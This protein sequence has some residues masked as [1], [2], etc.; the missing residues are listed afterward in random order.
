M[1]NLFYPIVVAVIILSATMPGFALTKPPLGGEIKVE[2]VADNEKEFHKIAHQDLVSGPTR[3]I[4]RYLEAKRGEQYAIVVRNNTPE[5]IGLVIAVDGRNIISGKRSELASRERMYV[6]NGYE[7]GRYEGWRTTNEEVHRFY[8]TK[9]ADSYSIR[10][11]GDKSAMGLIAVAVYREKE[12]PQPLIEE[13]SEL[14][15]PSAPSASGTPRSANKKLADE[16][17][18][19]FGDAHY[20]PVITVEFE[21]EGIPFQKTLVKYEWRETLCRKGLL[22]CGR[23]TGNRFWDDGGYAP[24]PP[25]YR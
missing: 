17:G 13:K 2:I 23:E 9:P 22:L 4:K 1:R 15:A 7:S 5:R 25:A 21:P 16:A 19:G 6:L 10:A 8:F 14:T 18:T 20:S 24:Y 3:I 12:K 11:F